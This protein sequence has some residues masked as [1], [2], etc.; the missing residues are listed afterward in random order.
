MSARQWWMDLRGT[1][2]FPAAGG[3]EDI[4]PAG[5]LSSDTTRLVTAERARQLTRAL[6][7]GD[8][9]F[10]SGGM[11]GVHTVREEGGAVESGFVRPDGMVITVRAAYR[12]GRTVRYEM[13]ATEGLQ[14]PVRRSV[15]AADARLHVGGS[16]DTVVPLPEL[17]WAVADYGMHEH[18]APA[19]ARLA[20]NGHGPALIAVYRPFPMRWDTVEV[21]VQPLRGP[22]LLASVR[23]GDVLEVVLLEKDGTLLYVERVEP[24]AF[25]RRPRTGTEQAKRLDALVA[26]VLRAAG[27]P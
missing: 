17:P 20:R 24:S 18:L 5:L 8:S 6:P 22:V 3:G 19:L 23:Q 12:D 21:T 14:E 27:Q 25:Y 1:A 7:H 16:R 13:L 2:G 15:H 26:E 9:T 11:S 10:S 4:V